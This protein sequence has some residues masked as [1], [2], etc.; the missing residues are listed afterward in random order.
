MNRTIF[1]LDT[2]FNEFNGELI[3]LA[4]VNVN[5]PRDYF[6]EVLEIEA[7]YGPW[8]KE[9][10]VPYLDRYPIQG[11]LPAFQ[12]KLSQFLFSHPGQIVILADWPDDIRYFCN[13]LITGPGEMIN[14]PP[15]I[16]QYSPFLSAAKSEV[17]HNAYY[18]ALAIAK[19]YKSMA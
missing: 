16:F 11:G 18:D 1:A 7:E 4:L 3:S 14:C 15:L 9:H 17:P 19:S 13:A 8:V 6:Y 10:V 2:E 12:Q 5:A